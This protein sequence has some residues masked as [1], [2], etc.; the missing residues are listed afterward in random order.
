MNKISI[1]I[2]TFNSALTIQKT[3]ESVLQQTYKNIEVIILDS[4]SKD[5]TVKKIKIF[6][7]KKIKIFS[8]SS[9]TNLSHIRY[10]GVLRSKGDYIC[11]LDSD[12]F[13]HK[14]KIQKQ[15]T[16]MKKNKLLA[17]STNFSLIKD[18]KKKSFYFKE[19]IKFNDLLY[20]RPI[21]NSSIMIEKKLI[22]AIAKKYRFISYAEDYLWWLKV[23]EKNIIYNLQENLTYLNI[24]RYN[25]TTK[26]FFKNFASLIYIYNNIYNYSFIKIIK[27]FLFVFVNNFKKKF[28]FYFA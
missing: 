14:Q 20:N 23:A 15:Y 26:G 11:F 9:K 25:R 16:Y 5:E 19:Q 2:P 4:F 28:F 6:R 13:W 1:I 27:I 21:A 22:K 7:S 17:S 10:L 18:K 24:S 8:I 12:D 3:I